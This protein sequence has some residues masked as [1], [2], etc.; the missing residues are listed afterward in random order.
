MSALPVDNF[1]RISCAGTSVRHNRCHLECIF[2]NKIA[3]YADFFGGFAEKTLKKNILQDSPLP[4][5]KC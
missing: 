3:Y 1:P 5:S 4:M 2:M